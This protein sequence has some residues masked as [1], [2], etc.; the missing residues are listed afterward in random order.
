MRQVCRALL[1]DA[2][3]VFYSGNRFVVHDYRD[4]IPYETPEFTALP[5]RVVGEDRS[6]TAKYH[7]D[8]LAAS[9]FLREVVPS[10]MLREIRD[11]E[12][13]FPPYGHTGWPEEGHLALADWAETLRWVR[14]KMNLRGLMLRL[15]MTD[16]PNGSVAPPGRASITAAQ[17]EEM[18]SA[19]PRIISPLA[20][21]AQYKAIDE[22]GG[23]GNELRKFY[24]RIALPWIWNFPADEM[25]KEYGWPWFENY[26]GEKRRLLWEE[27]EGLVMGPGYQEPCDESTGR[28]WNECNEWN[29]VWVEKFYCGI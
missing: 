23:N 21:L 29:S 11:L 27:A 4:D 14:D 17:V 9:V 13:V 25:I 7:S 22:N 19:Y 18:L 12:L 24:A 10:E 16:S 8:R 1:N 15:V 2:Q 26:L 20:A 3:V 5:P 28:Q 6:A